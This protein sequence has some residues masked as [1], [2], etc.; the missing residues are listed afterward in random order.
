MYK[1]FN[2]FVTN[3]NLK[4]NEKRIYIRFGWGYC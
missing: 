4:V 2:H 3:E 1:N